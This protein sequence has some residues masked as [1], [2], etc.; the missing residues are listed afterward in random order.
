MEIESEHIIGVLIT[1]AIVMIVVL[2]SYELIIRT[3]VGKG[4]GKFLGGVGAVLGAIGAQFTT[5]EKNGLFN[6]NKGCYLG[7]GFIGAGLLWGGV[8][9]GGALLNRPKTPPNENMERK[10]MLKGQSVSD[11]EYEFGQDAAQI[12]G[13]NDVDVSPNLDGAIY[14][15]VFNRLQAK[16]IMKAL[17]ESGLSP[18]DI[19]QMEAK[20]KA[21]YEAYDNQINADLSEGEVDEANAAADNYV[22]EP[23]W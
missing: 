18:Q 3:P 21:S 5:C 15:K 22:P 20:A 7:F 1:V 8:R 17:D 13:I 2:V 4:L 16:Q 9:L 14:Q 23:E 19:A 10:A 6:V 11:A 12:P